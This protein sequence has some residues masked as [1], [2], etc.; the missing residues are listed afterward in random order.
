MPS[1]PQVAE[2]ALLAFMNLV[3]PAVMAEDCSR[4]LNL[5]TNVSIP[6][7][8]VKS[9]CAAR[10]EASAGVSCVVLRLFQEAV[11]CAACSEMM[12]GILA[13]VTGAWRA[14]SMA[15]W[16]ELASW[17]SSSPVFPYECSEKAF[18]FWSELLGVCASTCSRRRFLS[19]SHRPR[20]SPRPAQCGEKWTRNRIFKPKKAGAGRAQAS[21]C[22]LRGRIEGACQCRPGRE[23]G[24][25]V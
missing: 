2:A 8:A 6:C 17:K 18:M 7:A 16:V 3:Q 12:K 23:G 11:V 19:N 13:W 14:A 10:R 20:W 5:N 1:E 9:S 25:L 4:V 24:V 21:E 15:T 22:V